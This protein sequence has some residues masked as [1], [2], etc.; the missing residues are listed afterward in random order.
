MATRKTIKVKAPTKREA[1]DAGKETRA[2][3]PAGGKVLVEQKVAKNAV[4]KKSSVKKA[5]AKKAPAKK[6]RHK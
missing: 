6:D 2:G 5:T 4:A 1:H 3:H